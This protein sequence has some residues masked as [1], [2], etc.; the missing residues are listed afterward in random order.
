MKKYLFVLFLLMTIQPLWALS[1]DK[2]SNYSDI[3]FLS[4]AELN[5]LANYELVEYRILKKIADL[6]STPIYYQAFPSKEVFFEDNVGSRYIQVAHWNI[7]RGLNLAAIQ[8]IFTNTD[9]YI[10]HSLLPGTTDAWKLLIKEEAEIFKSSDILTLNE[11]DWGIQ[12]SGYHNIAEEI[13]HSMQASYVFAPE[14]L[15]LDSSLLKDPLVKPA[16]YKGLHGNAIISK[17]PIKSAEIIQLP[18][19]YDWFKSEMANLSFLEHAR[20]GSSQTLINEK[21]A[22]ELRRGSRLAL[23]ADLLLPNND[24]LTVVSVHLENRTIPECRERQI[25]ALLHHLKNKTN[26]LILAGDLNNFEKS[27]EP[28][29]VSKIISRTV[30]DPQNLAQFAISYLNPYA[31]VVNSSSYALGTVRKHR[32]PTV[33]G[34]PIIMR[35]K[36]RGLFTRIRKHEFADGA[37]FDFG[38]DDKLSYNRRDGTLSNSNQRAVK[39]FV[40]TFKFNR[41]F[42]VGLFKI[43]W[44]FAKPVF[45]L[46]SVKKYYPAFGRTL[47]DLNNSYKDGSLSDHSPLTLKLYL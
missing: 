28:T 11:V 6:F 34:F 21:L 27:A 20:R 25:E 18:L 43:D 31:L 37:H 2:V 40:E 12:R 45:D 3:K 23:V 10:Q 47:K 26:P 35:N 22:T 32:D 46:N 1:L 38:G 8:K 36:A 39:G 33:I 30:S 44:I 17:F 29:S 7:E 4:F 42:G 24:V 16:L 14:F 15:E 5:T 9:D 13:A 19:C 41:S